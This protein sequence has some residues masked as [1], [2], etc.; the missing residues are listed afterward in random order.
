MKNKY[1]TKFKEIFCMIMGTTEVD[2]SWVMNELA[3]WDS[4][5][6]VQLL[7][8]LEDEL[9]LSL[10]YEDILSMTS[11]RKIDDVLCKY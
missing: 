4:L 11:I 9:N 1:E 10:D 6:H 2:E 5:K 7:S 8:E 3:E